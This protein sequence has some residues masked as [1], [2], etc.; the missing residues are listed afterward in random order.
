MSKNILQKPIGLFEI[1]IEDFPWPT[2]D[3]LITPERKPPPQL[4][5]W[6]G[7]KQRFAV[8][9]TKTFPLEYKRYFEPFVGSGA[10]LGAMSPK[11]AIA[12]DVLKPLIDLWKLLQENPD[13]LYLSYQKNWEEYIQKPKK[14]YSR[15]LA[16]YN[17][18][19]NAEDFLFISRTCYGGVIRFTKAGKM[20][21][22]MG[23]HSPISPD[24][25]KE[26][27]I[28]WRNRVKGTKFVCASF[29]E[30]MSEAKEGDIVYCDPPYVDSQ[31][32]LYGA[33]SFDINKLWE[34]IKDC[35]IR[36]AK[37][38]L[39]I[40]GRKKSGSKVIELNI[41][42]GLFERQLFIDNG[43]SMLKRFQKKDETMIG[44][45]VHDRLLL[46]W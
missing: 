7:N 31:T 10:I 1:Q 20:S 25:F 17:E 13:K 18:A 46:T 29:E 42:D 3:T 22:P 32:I 16:S 12:S 37:V 19:P 38:A 27:M 4:L 9:I 35:R 28:L 30:I 39:S 21:T 6:I 23:P 14:T 40:D 8:T 11:T 34:A 45:D 41:P 33:Q 26:R 15:I 36:G 43:S 24:S 2:F 44:E 5:K